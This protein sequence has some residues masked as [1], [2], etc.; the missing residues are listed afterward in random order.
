MGASS[1]SRHVLVVED[2]ENILA[3]L[4][5]LLADEGWVVHSAANGHEAIAELEVMPK[6]DL[7]V[8]DF[9]VPTMSSW[10]LLERLQKDPELATIPVQVVAGESEH[11]TN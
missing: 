1:R 5:A 8:V 11:G 3:V 10:A 2:D 4:R 9:M 7:I 6:P